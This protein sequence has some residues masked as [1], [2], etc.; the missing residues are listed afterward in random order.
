MVQSSRALV[1]ANR[2]GF[3]VTAQRVGLIMLVGN[4][5]EHIYSSP[6]ALLIDSLKLSIYENPS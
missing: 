2:I 5:K 3:P 6:V 4:W 1:I